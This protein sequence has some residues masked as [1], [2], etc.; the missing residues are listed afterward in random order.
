MNTLLVLT[1][2]SP[3]ATKA[4]EYGYDLAGKLGANII[5][6]NAIDNPT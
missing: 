6:C 3:N 2:F 1:N 5:L 4:A